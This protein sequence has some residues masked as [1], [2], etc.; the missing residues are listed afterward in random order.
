M[1]SSCALK[2]ELEVIEAGFDESVE[3]RFVERQAGGDEVDVEAGG[4]GGADEIEDVGACEGFAAGEIGLE[5][6][7]FGGFAGRRGTSLRGEFS[8]ASR[9]FEGV[10]AVD[11]VEWAAVGQF[12]DEGEGVGWRRHSD[13]V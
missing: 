12:G 4:A 10:R 1:S 8:G 3:S 11:A 13:L 9:Q 6:A 2:A 7:E 5:D